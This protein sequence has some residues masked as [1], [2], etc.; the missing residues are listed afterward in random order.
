MEK[1]GFQNQ[2][3]MRLTLGLA[4]VFL[5]AFWITNFGVYFS[6]MSLR[7]ASVV[8]YYDG[9]EEEFRPPRSAQS[10]L[11]TS[12]MHLPMMG[13]VLLF[14][15]H[16]AIFVPLSRPAKTTLILATFV[17]AMLEEGG[18]WLVRFVSPGFAPLKVLGFVGLQSTILLL[19][20][21]LGVFLWKSA[22]TPDA[23]PVT[24]ERRGSRRAAGDLRGEP[25]RSGSSSADEAVQISAPARE[26]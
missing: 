4:L 10:M 22:A 7:P 21:A 18:G 8:S 16:L 20:S 11:E 6:R 3:Q 23:A 15:T 1:G 2:P 13:M 14:L 24:L 19:L 5:L 25:A 17:S 12:H 26:R 9:S